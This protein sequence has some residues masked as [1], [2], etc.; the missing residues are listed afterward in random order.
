ME[1]NNIMIKILYTQEKNLFRKELCGKPWL[2]TRTFLPPH[3]K[4]KIHWDKEQ[5]I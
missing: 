4:N 3:S 5:I 1:D 2:S